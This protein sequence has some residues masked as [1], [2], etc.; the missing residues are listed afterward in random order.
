[1][2]KCT[3]TLL[4]VLLSMSAWAIP[5][6][7]GKVVLTQPDGTKIEVYVRGDEKFHYYETMDG[8][9]LLPGS[10]GLLKYAV[11]DGS[12]NMVAGEVNAKGVQTHCAKEKMAATKA[13]GNAIRTA[14]QKQIEKATTNNPGEIRRTFPTTGTVRGL[15]VLA[16]YQDVKFSKNG[17]LETFQQLAN[18]T[19]YQ[20][21]IAPGSMRD[22]FIA[23]SNGQFTPEFDVVGPVILPHNR[24]YYGGSSTG[25]ERIADMMKDAADLAHDQCHVDFSKYDVNN[26]DYVDF[27]YVIFAGHG[28]AQGGP[29]ESVWPCAMDLSNDVSIPEYDTKFIGKTACSCELH[30]AEGEEIDGI[31]TFCHEFSHILGLPDIY[32][33]NY[34][35]CFG[36]GHYDIMATGGYNND[37]KTPCGYTAMDK[38]TVGWLN[39]V[40][41]TEPGHYT[42]EDLQ[43]SN[44]AYFLV[45]PSNKNEYYTFENRQANAW[46]A[47]LPNHGML[48]SH[49]N[50]SQVLWNTNLVNTAKSG[51][52]HVQLIAADNKWNDEDEASDVFPGT[53][54]LYA[55]FTSA[56]T[57]AL[58]W[59][60]KEALEAGE[61]IVNIKQ[62][63]DGVISFDYVKPTTGISSIELQEQSSAYY[64]LEGQKV[65][66]D[67]MPKGIYIHDGKKVVVR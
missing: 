38:Y 22:Y 64:T 4:G 62:D 10:D 67:Q 53:D 2:K 52:E 14:L 23:Q 25:Q 45:S 7:P 3:L 16:E 55:S 11:I 28:Q 1:M 57:P 58:S 48:I 42:L 5:A 40:V 12:G 18:E 41:L 61:G 31:G 39:P 60:S 32:D 13:D 34:T 46:D 30:G 63:A 6:K 47:G 37:G 33:V 21:G 49:I 56:T 36:M 19:G 20:G 59:R 51:F 9:I 65:K 24:A 66:A 17:T 43:A 44:N 27:F 54:G 50:Y 35:S 15:I 8:K 29:V 26:D